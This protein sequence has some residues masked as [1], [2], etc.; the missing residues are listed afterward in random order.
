MADT[1][2]AHA[3]AAA[4]AGPVEGDGINYRGIVWFVAILIVTTLACQALMVW[5]MH[6]E[7]ERVAAPPALAAVPPAPN[8]VSLNSQDMPEGEPTNLARF[9]AS[10]DEILSTYGWIDRNGG[11][12]R[13][14]IDRAKALL[15][16]RGLPVRK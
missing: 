16:E 1:K 5:F 4:P 15:L 12:V 2:H 10:E 3:H 11:V 6:I 13:I 7:H 8:L 14:P 9:R